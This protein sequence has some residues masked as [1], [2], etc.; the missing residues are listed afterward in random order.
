MSEERKKRLAATNFR[1]KLLVM[2][3]RRREQR[4][5]GLM[6]GSRLPQE[7]DRQ[8][9]MRWYMHPAITD[10]ILSTHLFVSK[11]YRPEAAPAG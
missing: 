4:R 1:H 8:D 6:N 11:R 10:T 2:H 7:I 9:L 5:K 3:D